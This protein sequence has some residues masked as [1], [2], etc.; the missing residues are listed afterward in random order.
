MGAIPKLSISV[1]SGSKV[2]PSAGNTEVPIS[3]IIR[4]VVAGKISLV[5]V[6]A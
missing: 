2:C 4:I 3:G 6:L 5:M 1:P